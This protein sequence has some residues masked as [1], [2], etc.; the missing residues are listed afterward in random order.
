MRLF[1]RQ[2]VSVLVA[3]VLLSAVQS[4]YAQTD[5]ETVLIHVK[6]GLEQDDAQICVAYNQIWAALQAGYSVKVLVDASAVKTFKKGKLGGNKFEGYEIPE[7]LRQILSQ[8][9]G[10]PLEE[11]PKTYGDYTRMLRDKG[12]EFLVNSEMLV[13]YGIE[14]EYGKTENLVFDFFKPLK[15]KEVTELLSLVKHYW[16]Y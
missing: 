8:E 6:T 10:V 2:I 11:I 12:V 14:K 4:S 16:V 13:T 5:K 7:N 3:A 1:Q 9:F 15:I